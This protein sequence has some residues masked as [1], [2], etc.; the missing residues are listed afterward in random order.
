MI[1]K[2]RGNSEQP[3]ES[4]VEVQVP[5]IAQKVN[6]G[7]PEIDITTCTNSIMFFNPYPQIHPFHPH[8]LQASLHH[9]KDRLP[10]DP[11]VVG[12]GTGAAGM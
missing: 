6:H 1:S 9:Q 11:R 10:D 7:Q 8:R 2:Q 3:V 5:M 12:T 4:P